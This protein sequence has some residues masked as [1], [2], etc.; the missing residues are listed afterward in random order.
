MC[1]AKLRHYTPRP[2]IL[3]LMSARLSL[4]AALALALALPAASQTTSQLETAFPS[5]SF[6]EPIELTHAND[7]SGRL[8]V[9]EKAGRIRSF[10]NVRTTTGIT[11]ALDLSTLVL[12]SG[13]QGFLGFAFH[14]NHAANGYLYVHYSGRASGG[15]PAGRTVLARYTRSTTNPATFDPASAQIVLE[16]PQPFSNHNGGKLAFG[17][18]GYLYL[19]LGDG[20]SGGDPGNR[21][22][23]RAELLGKLLRFDVDNPAAPLNYGIPPTNP[24]VGNTLGYRQEIYAYGLRNMFKFSFDRQTGTL[25]GA[26]VGQGSWEEVDIITNGG[27]FGWRLMEGAHCFN[28]ST[29]CNQTGLTLPVYE[30]SS[31]DNTDECS[32]TGGTVYRGARNPELT[33]TYVFGDYCSGTVWG[34]TTDGTAT[35]RTLVEAGFGVIAFGEDA[36]GELYVLKQIT[37]AASIQRFV[38]TVVAGE[39]GAPAA[40]PSLRIAG[41]NPFTDR[42][43]VEVTAAAAGPVRVSVTDVL[44]REVAVLLDG[45]VAAGERRSLVVDGAGLAP[46]VY[47]VRMDAADGARTSLRLVRAR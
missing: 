44:G 33:G 17:P 6:S 36:A 8:Y 14:P 26:D 19:S 13:E 24:F 40:T 37:G 23:N 42:A 38:A 15:L 34:L 11:T 12:N 18:D 45:P 7:G 28:P 46:G 43:V 16:V 32:V 25:W 9:A 2:T 22:Q 47:L 5:L 35:S 10:D 31:Q 3:G 29:G 27:N 30:Y 1:A 39:A 21:A 4:F 41:A 20:G